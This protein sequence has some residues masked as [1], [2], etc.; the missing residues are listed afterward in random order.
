VQSGPRDTFMAQGHEG[1]LVVVVPSKDLVL[2][3]LGL[4]DDKKGFG[5]LG[6]WIGSV[7]A[8]FPDAER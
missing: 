4:F 2:V 5:A 8:L 6:E 3:R 7:V 1:Q